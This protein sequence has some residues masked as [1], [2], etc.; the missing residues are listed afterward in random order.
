MVIDCIVMTI[1]FIAFT[2]TAY[3]GY[4]R[5]YWWLQFVSVNS[6]VA[7]TNSLKE[8]VPT[9]YINSID[10]GRILIGIIIF[11]I[12]G[13]GYYNEFKKVKARN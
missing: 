12:F 4:K 7:F 8:I 3:L 1:F 6:F 11:I 10:T 2:S 13:V 5:N 9:K